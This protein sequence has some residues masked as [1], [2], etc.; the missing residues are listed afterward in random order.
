MSNTVDE[1]TF[2]LVVNNV[3]YPII[4]HPK[5]VAFSSLKPLN[6]GRSWIGFQSKNSVADAIVDFVGQAVHLLLG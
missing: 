2:R 1:D 5:P 6:A 4:S 3:E